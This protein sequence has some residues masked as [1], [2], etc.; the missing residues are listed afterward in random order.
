MFRS[1]AKVSRLLEC[2]VCGDAFTVIGYVRKGY[3]RKLCSRDCIGEFNRRR[4]FYD[5]LDKTDV[6]REEHP[7]L[8]YVVADHDVLTNRFGLDLSQVRLHEVSAQV[9]ER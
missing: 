6:F 8:N 7:E 9:Q 3:E 5:R 4:K 2:V 1:S